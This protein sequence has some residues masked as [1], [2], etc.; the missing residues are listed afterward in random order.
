[1]EAAALFLIAAAHRLLTAAG[2]FVYVGLIEFKKIPFIGRSQFEFGWKP[3]AAYFPLSKKL[4]GDP[5]LFGNA[6]RNRT[7]IFAS[8]RPG[9]HFG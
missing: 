8:E 5:G 7:I 9:R 1:M 4:T 3:G 2:V 6:T